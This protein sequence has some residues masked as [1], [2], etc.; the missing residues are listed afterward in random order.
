MK[1]EVFINYVKCTWSAVVGEYDEYEGT[2]I[3]NRLTNHVI[4]DWYE[5]PEDENITE[6]IEEELKSR[7][8]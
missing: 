7:I 5:V 2:F 6:A 4:I 1:I 8:C 3:H